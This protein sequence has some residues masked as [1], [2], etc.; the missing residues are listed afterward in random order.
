MNNTVIFEGRFHYRIS[1]AVIVL[2]V[3]P[4]IPPAE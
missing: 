3:L 2:I 4:A 1:P